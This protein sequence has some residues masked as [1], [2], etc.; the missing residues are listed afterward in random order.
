MNAPLR[1]A[2]V[3]AGIMGRQHYQHLRNVPQAQLC[4]V[5]DPGPQAEAFAVDCGVP[6]FADHRQMLQ[7]VQPE[8]VIIANPNN[9]HVATALDC[10]EAGVPVLVEKPVGVQLQEVRA[11][12]EASR[13]CKVPVLVGHHRRH[14]P[15]IAK[16]HQVISE[17]KLGRLI[18]VT[19]LWQLQKPDSYFD[20]AWR[21][22]PGAGFLLTNL[23]HDLD[24]LRYLCGEVVQ[25]QAFTRNDVRGFANEDSAAVLL[26][27]A[28]GALGSLTGSDAVAAPWSWE[29]D[30]GES[31]VYPRQDGQPCYLLAGTQGSLSIPQLKHWH[32][33]EPGSGWHT[34]LLQHQHSIPAGEA[35]TLQLQHFVRVAR[36]EQPPLVDAADAGRTLALIEAIRQAAASGRACAPEH[37]A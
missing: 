17:G 24:L 32:Y 36:G 33:A 25:V 23:I 2:L 11:L 21:R 15:L 34:P 27:F 35:L 19:A 12:V 37:I 16:A 20:T 9:Q 10:V 6:Y 1:I 3:G 22:E 13:R 5:A 30:S 8:A 18:N 4:A 28:N 14:N 31:P 26:Q 7:R 29:L